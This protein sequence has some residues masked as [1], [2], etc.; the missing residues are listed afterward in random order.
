MRIAVITPYFRESLSILHQCHRS[1]QAQSVPCTHVMVAD[2]FPSANIESWEVDHVILPRAHDDAGST[3]RA[4]GSFHAVGLG[5]DAV[6][7]L[8]ADNW[9]RPDHLETL[10]RLHARTGASF[11]SASRLLCRLDGS[12]MGPCAMCDGTTFIDT[13]CMLIM[14][15]A[16]G[17]LANWCLIP[18]YA[19]VVS[20]RAFLYLARAA[21]TTFAH[22]P[23]PTLHYRCKRSDAYLRMGESPP[24][25]AQPAPDYATGFRRWIEDGHRPLI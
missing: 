16:F 12:V 25:E 10:L 13:S 14:R 22:S 5:Y 24:P 11:L 8:D 1:V 23:E 20:D 21:G 19:H 7:F 4:I 18:P 9:Y 6:A 17:V 2:G 15:P 3:P